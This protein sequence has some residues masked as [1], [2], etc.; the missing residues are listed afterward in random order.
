MAILKLSARFALCASLIFASF[1]CAFAGEEDFKNA[2]EFTFRDGLP[3]FYKKLND[4]KSPVKIAYFG[5]SIT[6]QKGWRCHSLQYFKKRFPKADISEID[7]AIGGTASN[8]GAYRLEKD[9]L[10]YK[11]DLVFVEF[12]TNDSGTPAPMLT[13]SMEGIV[14][15]IWRDNPRTDICFVYTVTFSSLPAFRDGKNTGAT[16]TM[17]RVAARYGIPTI[18]MSLEIA[19]LEKAG[20][21]AIKTSEQPPERVS[22]A[23]L[24]TFAELPTTADGKIPFSADGVHPH[25]NTG[26]VLYERALERSFAKLEKL[27]ADKPHA[28]GEPISD[29]CIENGRMV[30]FEDDKIKKEGPWRITDNP[31]RIFK[32]RM[33]SVLEFPPNSSVSFKYRGRNLSVYHIMGN[34]G[35]S[36]DIFIDGK[37]VKNEKCFD[38][39]AYD[40]LNSFEILSLDKPKTVEIK[41]VVSDKTYDKRSILR[42]KYA[43]LFDKHQ[44]EFR[45]FKFNPGELL[46]DGELLD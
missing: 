23:E 32:S 5:G 10:Q 16:E 28:L 27:A 38:G 6:A 43:H 12:A 46:M 9:V 42:P 22:G 33:K 21:L 11:P 37:F 30:S 17:E 7:A 36:V 45:Q 40:R 39:Y 14:R 26:H 19:A 29:S 13:K 34:R 24:D 3:N 41:I 44:N 8:L 35:G 1:A 31:T 4:A 2:R 20:K 25:V 15:H 18:N